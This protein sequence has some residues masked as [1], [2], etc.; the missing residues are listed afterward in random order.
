MLSAAEKL[1]SGFVFPPPPTETGTTIM[2]V[3]FKDG[4][5][6]G[7]DSR[8]SAGIMIGN[9]VTDKLTEVRKIC[10]PFNTRIKSVN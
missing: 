3:Q 8:S 4:V 6:I 2:A 5:V 7:A 9:R 10:F 1:Q